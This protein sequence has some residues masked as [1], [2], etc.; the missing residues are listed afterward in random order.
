MEETKTLDRLAV[1]RQATVA[2]LSA[3][4]EQRRRML[5]LGFVPGLRRLRRGHRPAP[6][7]RAADRH[8][9]RA[10]RSGANSPG[11]HRSGLRGPRRNH[12]ARGP[13]RFPRRG[14]GKFPPVFFVLF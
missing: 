12:T 11:T 14:G 8:T 13:F 6:G 10:L 9:Y 4:A 5:E 7:G 3:P 1:G 2:A